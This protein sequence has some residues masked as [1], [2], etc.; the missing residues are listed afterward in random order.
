MTYKLLVLLLELSVV[1]RHFRFSQQLLVLFLCQVIEDVVDGS[2][3]LGN[4]LFDFVLEEVEVVK[5]H[6]SFVSCVELG[7]DNRLEAVLKR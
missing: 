6:E 3:L 1:L 5:Q 4:A 2:R 7:V